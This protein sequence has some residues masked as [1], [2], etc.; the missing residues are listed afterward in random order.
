MMPTRKVLT[1][2]SR[3][4]SLRRR[5][6]ME[7]PNL[8]PVHPLHVDALISP[9]YYVKR[10]ASVRAMLEEAAARG[11][12]QVCHVI[13]PGVDVRRFAKPPL[14]SGDARGGGGRTWAVG[15]MGRLAEEKSPGLFVSKSLS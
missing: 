6:Y 15:F 14:P 2:F 10:H 1:L 12:K 13:N 5:V 4:L 9:S 11:R 8:F 7:M 3:S